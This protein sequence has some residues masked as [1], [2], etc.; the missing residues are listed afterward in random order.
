MEKNVSKEEI[1]GEL[2][3]WDRMGVSFKQAVRRDLTQ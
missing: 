3:G 2:E 1:Q